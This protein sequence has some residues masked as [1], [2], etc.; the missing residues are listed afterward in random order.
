MKKSMGI[1]KCVDN[2]VILHCIYEYKSHPV[3]DNK[4]YPTLY[5]L[6]SP[7]TACQRAVCQPISDRCWSDI[8]NL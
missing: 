5:S 2:N 1:M 6:I 4:D 8:S 3:I 7:N